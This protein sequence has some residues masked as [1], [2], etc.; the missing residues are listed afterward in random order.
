MNDKFDELAKGIAQSVTRRGA[1]KK[2]GLGLAGIALGWLGAA[3]AHADHCKAS[4][5][6]CSHGSQCCSGICD[7]NFFKGYRVCF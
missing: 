3:S 5:S 7:F 4:G 2:F 1:L 6:K